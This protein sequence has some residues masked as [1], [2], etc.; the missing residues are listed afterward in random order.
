V[1]EEISIQRLNLLMTEFFKLQGNPEINI[2]LYAA[3]V[4]KLFSVER[5]ND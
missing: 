2:D 3:K 5:H 4:E 1:Y